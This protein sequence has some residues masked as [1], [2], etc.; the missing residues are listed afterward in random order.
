MKRVYE[1]IRQAGEICY[2]DVSFSFNLLNNLVILLYTSC[3]AGA[4][5]LDLF[6]TSD[7]S[8]VTIEFAINKLK[9]GQDADVDP[10]VFI[11]DDSAAERNAIEF[12]WP[13][14]RRFLCVF[15]IL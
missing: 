3:A 11:T 10:S 12:C 9:F 13:S 2:F 1:R 8:E 7:K 14:S 15:H 4:L 5:L 6:L